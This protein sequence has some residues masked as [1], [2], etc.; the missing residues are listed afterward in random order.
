MASGTPLS[1]RL[2]AASSAT[3]THCLFHPFVVGVGSG[4]LPMAAFQQFLK[5]DA[6]YLHGFLKAFAYAVVKAEAPADAMVLV[7]LM[8]GVNSELQLHASFM[9]SWGIPA[10]AIDATSA[11]QATRAYVDFLLATAKTATSV[12]EILAAMV[13]CARL[14]AFLGAALAS[15]RS[16]LTGE[17][18]GDAHQ[19]AKWIE[20]YAAPAFEAGASDMEA[21]LDSVAEREGIDEARLQPLYARAMQL[22]YNFFDASFPVQ[23]ADF[24]GTTALAYDADTATS[25][26]TTQP[27]APLPTVSKLSL[28]AAVLAIA[29][30]D[31]SD[32]I[33]HGVRDGSEDD[34]A[35]CLALL[36]RSPGATATEAAPGVPRVLCI[37]GSDSGGGA[38]IQAD[39]KTCTALG[40][41]STSAITAITV[42]NTVGVHGIHG[43]PIATLREQI[44][45]VLDDIGTDV[46]K[47]GMLGSAAVVQC[48]VDAVKDRN[49]PLVVDPVMVST[50]GH[51]LLELDAHHC[52]VQQLFPLALIITPNIPEASF[53]LNGRTIATVDDMKVAAADLHALGG[54]RYVLV[55]GGH[56]EDASSVVDVLYDGLSWHC[57]QSQRVATINTHGTGCTLASAIAAHYAKV[58]DMKAAVQ[59][60]IRY[61]H[62]IL[63]GSQD[64]SVGCGAQGPMLH[65]L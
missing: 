23:R 4:Q 59:N 10:H 38:G 51:K 16:E 18:M 8:H 62:A 9:E 55:K 31:H 46:I 64:L 42:Q 6:F 35:A 20:T 33:A 14:Y 21:L 27:L 57:F 30:G 44:G 37:A 24:M 47:T 13:P 49:L 29:A 52:I 22:E 28:L 43:V 3:A 40:V 48:V 65:W 41:F 7:D 50:S 15:A 11:A 61:V 53:L 39:M 2:W 54:S 60:A 19:Y 17:L 63:V 1:R 26:L 5:Q 32:P 25:I 12:A 58:P 45:C 56:L 36:T 34:R